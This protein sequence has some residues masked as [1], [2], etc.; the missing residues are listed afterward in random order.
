MNQRFL[1]AFGINIQLPFKSLHGDIWRP[2]TLP[3]I[4]FS[5]PI[6]Y[7]IWHWNGLG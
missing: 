7:L 4:F 3:Q 5:P 2:G 6:G 1:E